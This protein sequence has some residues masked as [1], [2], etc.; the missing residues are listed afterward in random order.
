MIAVFKQRLLGR[1][2][3]PGINFV[4]TEQEKT[5]TAPVY[6][7]SSIMDYYEIVVDVD[8]AATPSDHSGLVGAEPTTMT[9][10]C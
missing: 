8:R 9:R 7:T 5:F 6:V 1:R 3:L 4:L 10:S 2:V